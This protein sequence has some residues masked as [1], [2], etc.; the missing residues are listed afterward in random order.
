[1]MTAAERAR[2]IITALQESY[3]LAERIFNLKQNTP[4]D[5]LQKA[6]TEIE[7]VSASLDAA[8]KESLGGH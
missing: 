6:Y 4:S 1:M 2:E 7:G 5:T 3:A 8:L